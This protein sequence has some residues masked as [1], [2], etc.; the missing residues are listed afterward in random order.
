MDLW[1]YW[2]GTTMASGWWKWI[3]VAYE[4]DHKILA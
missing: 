4:I 3:P 2:N 1:K